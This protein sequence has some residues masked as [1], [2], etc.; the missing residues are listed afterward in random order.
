MDA[1]HIEDR[2]PDNTGLDDGPLLPK[3]SRDLV[4]N[5]AMRA[6]WE[7]GKS[8]RAIGAQYGVSHDTVWRV[9]RYASRK[10]RKQG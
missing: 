1:K 9:V 3:R 2:R 6:D 7:A 8:L 5:F 10:K 4:R